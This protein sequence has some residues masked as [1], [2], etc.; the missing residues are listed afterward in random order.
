[1]WT[2]TLDLKLKRALLTRLLGLVYP[3]IYY[4]P[5]SPLRVTN[6]RRPM[7]PAASWVRVRN[8]L[9]GINGND[10][11][12][13][14]ADIGIRTS[15]AALPHYKPAYAGHEVVGEV[16]EIGEDVQHLRVGDR[17]VLQ[18]N[19]NCLSS[20]A[21]PICDACSMGNYNLCEYG[22]LPGPQPIGGGWSEE[23][24][25]HEQQL[26]RL[27]DELSDEQ[28]VMLEPTAIALHA[29]LRHL[30][31]ADENVLVIGA[32]TVGLLTLSLLRML[33]P[34]ANISIFARYPCQVEYATRLGAD[35]IVYPID[36]YA[37]VERAT[38]AQLYTA[39]LGNRTIVGGYD[40]IYD[41]VGQQKTLHHALRWLRT[42]GTVVLVGRNLHMMNIDLTPI[43]QQEMN[44][45]GSLSHGREIWP[46]ETSVSTSTFSVVAELMQQR[47]IHPEQLITHRFGL[48]A[49]KDAFLAAKKKKRSRA[50][51][52]LFDYALLSASTV[53]NVRASARAQHPEL[54][55]P[56]GDEFLQELARAQSAERSMQE[57]EQEAVAHADSVQQASLP[58]ILDTP[59]PQALP[60]ETWHDIQNEQEIDQDYADED[61]DPALPVV[62]AQSSSSVNS[63]V[64]ESP[65]TPI[66]PAMEPPDTPVVA[67]TGEFGANFHLVQPM[68]EPQQAEAESN[69]S[70]R[71]DDT[72]LQFPVELPANEEEPIL[73]F[74][75]MTGVDALTEDQ[76]PTQTVLDNLDADTSL[77]PEFLAHLSNFDALD[78][79]VTPVSKA[80]DEQFSD[81]SFAGLPVEHGEVRADVE[82][83]DVDAGEADADRVT[84]VDEIPDADARIEH[85][86]DAD[87]TLVGMARIEHVEN[88][89]LPDGGMGDNVGEV[90]TDE[91]LRTEASPAST[92]ADVSVT[93]ASGGEVESDTSAM[94]VSAGERGTDADATEADAKSMAGAEHTD[95][96]S[97]VTTTAKMKAK[98]KR[99]AAGSAKTMAI[100]NDG[101]DEKS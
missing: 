59:H 71:T 13:V 89:V 9:A 10:L 39:A 84:N 82:S 46:L 5:L 91:G 56:Q 23:M 26:F 70:L 43:W 75:E 22:S 90:G 76:L 7:L 44:L 50:I 11:S 40:V 27:P 25:V 28:G 58:K 37:S 64:V 33:V 95:K 83:R 69:F 38:H 30:P 97:A 57:P 20:G 35:H 67:E 14:H 31:Q 36:P 34:K 78:V 8:R 41:T 81:T 101:G 65:Q 17:V 42:Q 93:E 51:K 24:L 96:V 47:R 32:G 99:K 3:N 87:M 74:P 88:S 73:V 98:R 48:N 92:D 63:R 86:G 68:R 4:S 6:T 29:I 18:Y 54:S 60:D 79:P 15:V 100:Q 53:P 66:P 45:L 16:I 2:S 52:V 62:R 55:Q 49:Y 12:F 80:E 85:A 19:P 1:M 94:D 61:T 21:R 77:M 72:S